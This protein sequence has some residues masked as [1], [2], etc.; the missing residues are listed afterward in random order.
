MKPGRRSGEEVTLIKSLRLAV[1][2]V[3][4]AEMVYCQALDGA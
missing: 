3:A 2:D 4:T 1:E